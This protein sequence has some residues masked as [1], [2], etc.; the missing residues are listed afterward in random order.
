MNGPGITEIELDCGPCFGTCPVFRVT[1][2]S[3]GTYHYE[4]RHYV[5]P[6]GERSG[7]FPEWLFARVTEVCAA[8]GV[9]SLDDVYPTDFDDTQSVTVRV[10]HAGG[11]KTVRCEGS[12]G[13][14][15]RLWAFAVVVEHAMREAFAIEDRDRGPKNLGHLKRGHR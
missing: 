5:E 6:L 2:S 15:P 8:L 10:R 11:V 1:L 7:R 14:V 13:L 4:G 12:D 3:A 9:L